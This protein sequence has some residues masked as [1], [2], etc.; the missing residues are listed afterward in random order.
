MWHRNTELIFINHVLKNHFHHMETKCTKKGEMLLR[1]AN[2][3]LPGG[4]SV[5]SMQKTA[6]HGVCE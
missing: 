6:T 2:A 4:P 1:C 5:E 3:S